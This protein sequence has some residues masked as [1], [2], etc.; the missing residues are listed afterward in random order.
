MGLM[1]SVLG[2]YFGQSIVGLKHLDAR[3]HVPVRPGDTL[4]CQWTITRK[5]PRPHLSGGGIVH[6]EGEGAVGRGADRAVCLACTASLAVA[7][8]DTLHDGLVARRG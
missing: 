2:Q 6:L 7:A 3:F 5:D 8:R 4:R 1:T